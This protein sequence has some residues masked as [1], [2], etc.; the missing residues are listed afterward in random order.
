V[1]I[2][3]TGLRRG[4]ALVVHIN[5]VADLLGHSSIAITG[6]I[7]GHAGD[8]ATRSVVDGLSDMPGL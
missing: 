3:T 2:A 8:A 7:C 6:D 5:A 1:L 4:E